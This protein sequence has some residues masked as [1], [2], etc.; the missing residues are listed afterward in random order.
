MLM[1]RDVC[2]FLFN[3]FKSDN[4]EKYNE[5]EINQPDNTAEK[6]WS[7]FLIASI[8]CL[9]FAYGLNMIYDSEE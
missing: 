6:I 7:I 4:N 2:R 5:P 1:E 3:G 9:I 8:I